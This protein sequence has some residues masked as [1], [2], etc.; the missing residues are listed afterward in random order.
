MALLTTGGSYPKEG[1]GFRNTEEFFDH[2]T[3]K[4]GMV[5]GIGSG[6]GVNCS[7][8]GI[9]IGISSFSFSRAYFKHRIDTSLYQ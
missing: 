3:R 9:D 6:S 8:V 5:G 7:K 4:E 2:G 1:G